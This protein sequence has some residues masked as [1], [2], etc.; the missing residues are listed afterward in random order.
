MSKKTASIK[1][2]L[3]ADGL[4]AEKVPHFKTRD[5]QIELA[6]AI[7]QTLKSHQT[8]IAEAGTGTGKTFAYLLPAWFSKGKVL[9]ST[10]TKNLQDQLF[11]RDIPALR[12]ILNIPKKTA[13]LKGRANY[14]CL[15]RLDLNQSEVDFLNPKYQKEYAFA[16]EWARRTSDG[17]LSQLSEVTDDSPII[18][19]VTS[20]KDNCL[21]SDCLHYEDCF[22]MKARKKAHA[23]E[24]IVVNHHL[25]FADMGLREEGI[26]DLLPDVDAVILDEAHQVHDIATQYFG[27]GI[28][29]REITDLIEDSFAES[30]VHAKDMSEFRTLRDRALHHI[31]MLRLAFGRE[32][33][34]FA[35]SEKLNKDLLDAFDLLGD[36]LST[37][38]ELLN[39]AKDRSPGLAQCFE[40]SEEIFERYGQLSESTQ[41]NAIH[42]IEL[43][44]KS[45]AIHHTPVSIAT[46][47]DDIRK[48]YAKSWVFTSA[49]L[50]VH[51]GFSHFQ[52]NLGLK[53]A[54]TLSLDSPFDYAKQALL[55]LP[56][57][58][59]EPKSVHYQ[60]KLLVLAKELIVSMGGRTFFLFTSYKAMNEAYNILQPQLRGINC[61]L[62]GTKPKSQILDE[63]VTQAPAVIF[64]TASF[65]EGVD[66][67]GDALS[68]V[69][70]DKLPF[71]SPYDPITRARSALL[72]QQ[73]IDSF[74]HDQIPQAV[75]RLKQGVG[76]LLRTE[77]DKGV[78]MI[79]DPRLWS[80]EYGRYF[81]ASI[82]L[83]ARTR[84]LTKTKAFFDVD[85]SD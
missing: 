4:F 3:G 67:P 74:T 82:P 21:Q 10:G 5:V 46:I 22:L 17:D 80:R 54:V 32:E 14:L 75:I 71:P 12:R 13:L 70:I 18:P 7:Q 42:W 38:I 11:Y 39:I 64:A 48:K 27:L 15:Y 66:V 84:C 20:N 59:P 58:M 19:L 55:Y 41:E 37:L 8:L 47:F 56:R 50:S 51:G 25:L 63:F 34:R 73:G 43:F 65:W 24:I 61:L 31:Q 49:T 60:D 85:V 77:T 76:R 36:D 26:V 35:W 16:T 1:S 40:R 28:S 44:S 68:C 2:L 57:N 45:F 33:G 29:S 62:Q 9:I 6:E 69:I 52:E 30:F 81:F 83:F 53:E 78:I 23:A 72:K 79:A